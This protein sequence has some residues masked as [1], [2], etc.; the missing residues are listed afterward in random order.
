MSANSIVSDILEEIIEIVRDE[1]TVK[2][3]IHFLFGS[4]QIFYGT[5][6]YSPDEYM[7]EMDD[8]FE[9]VPH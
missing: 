1:I 4:P 2:K 8:V 7:Y 9:D 3:D 5:D 6:Y